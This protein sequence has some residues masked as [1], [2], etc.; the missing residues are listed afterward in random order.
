[1]ILPVSVPDQLMADGERT[2]RPVPLGAACHGNQ[3]DGQ[4]T[5]LLAHDWLSSGYYECPPG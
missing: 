5:I 2:D 3:H 1:M 4:Q